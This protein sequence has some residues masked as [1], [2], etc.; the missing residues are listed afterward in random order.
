M[1]V[2]AAEPVTHQT[3]PLAKLRDLLVLGLCGLREKLE[4]HTNLPKI[5]AIVNN[6]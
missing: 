4:K 6:R 3:V 2:D 5:C 1:D